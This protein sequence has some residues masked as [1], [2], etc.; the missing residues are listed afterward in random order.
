[1][2]KLQH[3]VSVVLLVLAS[4]P[5][6]GR[7]GAGVRVQGLA[8][9][10]GSVS[11]LH[12]EGLR[13][14]RAARRPAQ[15]NADIFLKVPANFTIPDHWHTSAERMVLVSGELHVT[16]EGQPTAVLKPGMYAYGPARL[17]HRAVCES[18]CT[19]CAVHRIRGARR[20]GGG[21]GRLRVAASPSAAPQAR[22]IR[23]GCD[24]R[25]SRTRTGR[26]AGKSAARRRSRSDSPRLWCAR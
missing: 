19:V 1:M 3:V 23:R 7:A 26:T 22:R 11:G 4:P 18:A 15:A 24:R 8:A 10:V 25:R 12:P 17:A 21:Q 20:R 5:H 2:L 16:Y 6:R 9:R 14:R 13:D